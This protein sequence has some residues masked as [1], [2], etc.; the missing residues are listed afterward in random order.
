MIR[1]QA[2][3]P[4]IRTA[5]DPAAEVRLL[6]VRFD[7]I[8]RGAVLERIESAFGRREARKI[9]IANAHTLNL[10]WSDPDF[11]DVLNGADLLLN[12]GSGVQMAARLAGRP[13]PDNLVGT[14]LTPL[15]C[16]RAAARGVGVFLLGGRPGVPE[17]AA[18]RLVALVPGLRVCGSHH[19][20]ID[21][22]D[23]E[24]I[25]RLING[26]GAGLLLV[27][28][29]NPLQE[30][31]IHRHAPHLSVD[32]CLGIGGLIDHLA[33]RLRR[34][35][36]WMRRLGIE[37][38]HILIGQPHKWRR[39]LVGNPLFVARALADRLGLRP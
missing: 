3:T 32:V 16:A 33:G 38:V 10:A 35:P 27:A 21:A 11:R 28:L 22:G 37:W 26:S 1:A 19:G 29:G 12:D 5:P 15:V 25:R 6:G 7:R 34:A 2:E 24:R 13:F 14:D 18:A 31:W 4:R 36:P 30:S 8:P 20:Y 39:Y 9:Y 23:S 17:R